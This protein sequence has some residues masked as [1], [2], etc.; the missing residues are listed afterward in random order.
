[1]TVIAR[2]EVL[3]KD[4][5]ALPLTTSLTPRLPASVDWCQIQPA[6]F[7]LLRPSQLVLH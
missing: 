3:D 7:H 6:L 4:L 5:Y 2:P 1:M